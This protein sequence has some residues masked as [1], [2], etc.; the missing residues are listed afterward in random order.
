MLHSWY[1]WHMYS[2]WWQ[3]WCVHPHK[4][5]ADLLLLLNIVIPSWAV[6]TE[7][8]EVPL[9]V[10]TDIQPVLCTDVQTE[11]CVIV[12]YKVFRRSKEQIT[13]PWWKPNEHC[14]CLQ[15][16]TTINVLGITQQYI[17]KCILQISKH[18][19]ND[20]QFIHKEIYGERV[21]VSWSKKLIV[22]LSNLDEAVLIIHVNETLS[23]AFDN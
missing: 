11:T 16:H 18:I 22:N 8:T 1:Q 9:D 17:T 15:E 19:F 23:K 4:I 12:Q 20:I 14:L 21:C 2:R 7:E 5:E 3:M 6:T 10:K 13:G